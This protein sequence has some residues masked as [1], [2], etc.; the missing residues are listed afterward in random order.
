MLASYFPST[1]LNAPR[2][3]ECF[4]PTA[5]SIVL[6][7][8]KKKKAA[9]K[10]DRASNVTVVML[11]EYSSSI[12]KGKVRQNLAATGR[13]LSVRFSRCMSGQEVTNQL[14]R[15]FKVA[16]FVVLECDSSGHNLIRCADQ[17]LDGEKAVDRK[18]TLYLCESTHKRYCHP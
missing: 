7:M 4:D 18:G 14:I 10:R 2:K 17:L 5:E 15:T 1:S 6:P 9:A 13:I 8:Q 3:R 11:K 12:P 16:K